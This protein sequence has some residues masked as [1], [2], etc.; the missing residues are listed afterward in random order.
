M[1]R[2]DKIQLLANLCD[3]LKS[4]EQFEDQFSS[5]M[6]CFN[7]LKKQESGYEWDSEKKELQRIKFNKAE[8]VKYYFCIKDY[9]SGGK[10]IASKGD[11]VQ[12]LRGLPIMGLEDISEHFMPVNN[13]YSHDWSEDDEIGE[14][15]PQRK[16]ERKIKL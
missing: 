16:N 5:A 3:R 6:A 7:L 4:D 11:V 1:T 13:V 12:A 9:F 8:H 10:K 15:S 14:W 2:E